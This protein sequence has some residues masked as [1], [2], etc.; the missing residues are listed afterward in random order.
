MRVANSG[1]VMRC[2]PP[3]AVV[4]GEHK[5]NRQA[6][7]EREERDLA[8]LFGPVEGLADVFETPRGSPR[9]PRRVQS[10]S[11]RR[12]AR[13]SVKTRRHQ[14]RLAS[15]GWTCETSTDAREACPFASM[16]LLRY[17]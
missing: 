12:T 14:R 7:Q 17:R 13:L 4:P 8:E 6:D 15:N 5:D 1:L 2:C 10:I 9:C 16:G 11:P 3:V